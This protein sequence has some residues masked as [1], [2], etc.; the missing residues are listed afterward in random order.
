MFV[1]LITNTINGKRYVGQTA[2]SLKMRWWQHCNQK[3]C[4]HLSRAI[5]K[6]GKENF[7]IESIVDAPTRELA[8]EFEKEYIAR[9]CTLAHNGYNLTTGGDRYEMTQATR[10]KMS[11]AHS[12]ANR[13]WVSTRMKAYWTDERRKTASKQRAANKNSN[14]SLNWDQVNEIRRCY[15]TGMY[16]QQ[17][18]GKLF[19]VGQSAI[20]SIVRNEQWFSPDY[21]SRKR[22]WTSSLCPQPRS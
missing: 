18:L 5:L 8:N 2:Q 10:E 20:S 3:N 12:G 15:A 13:P 4:H 17:R 22:T 19:N 14:A 21:I 1:Y 11:R 9:Y 6:Y 16:S 7:I